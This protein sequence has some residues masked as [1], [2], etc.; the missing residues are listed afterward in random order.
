MDVYPAI[1]LLD[2]RCV[3]LVQGDYQR[4]LQFEADPVEVARSYEDAGAPWVHVVD[5]D[6]ARTGEPRNRKVVAAIAEAVAVPVQAG[7]GV[8][9]EAAASALFDAGVSRVVV[10]TASL[11]DPG[12]VRRMAARW[13]VAVGLDV[14]RQD[15]R[16]EPALRGWA[17]GSGAD[18][19]DVLRTYEDAG[20][21]AVVVTDIARD[22]MLSGP[23]LALLAEVLEATSVPVVAS[24]GVA[25][26][27][28]LRALA[29]L[30]TPGGRRLAGAIVGRALYQRAFTVAAAVEAAR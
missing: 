18:L 11:E 4:Q 22:G 10:G 24:G 3:R 1:D 12:L 8:R 17:E 26:L 13:P 30:A 14:R 5:L 21:A 6:A 20:V 19:L 2:G 23:S 16:W 9:D 27:D 25:S 15:D 28:D 29:G 7:G